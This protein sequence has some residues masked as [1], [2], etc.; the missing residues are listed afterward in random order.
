MG[1]QEF[2]F[3]RLQVIVVQTE[4]EPEGTIGHPASPLEHDHGVIEHLLKGHGRPSTTL[5][6]VSQEC[7]TRQGGVSLESARR[8]YQESGGMAG[9]IPPLC[10]EQPDKVQNT[11]NGWSS[12][13]T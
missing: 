6:Y 7:N 4:L 9:E 2:V 11:G 3:E 1:V 5:T 8:V 13:V 12:S 10:G